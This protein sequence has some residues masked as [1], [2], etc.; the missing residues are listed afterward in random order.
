M[1]WWQNRH[2]KTA[3]ERREQRLRAEAR[4]ACRLMRGLEQV[5]AHRG[6][7]LSRVGVALR[8]ALAGLEATQPEPADTAAPDE[9][10]RTQAE[11]IAELERQRI[12]LERLAAD[13]AQRAADELATVIPDSEKKTDEL[14]SAVFSRVLDGV[15]CYGVV[16]DT[17]AVEEEWPATVQCHVRPR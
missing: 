13:A 1:E 8:A 17:C 4:M 6:C 11:L 16:T 14:Y 3:S 10:A 5:H 9:A 15:A 7:K 12:E 2:K